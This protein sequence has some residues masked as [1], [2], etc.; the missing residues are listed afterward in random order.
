M[1]KSDGKCFAML[2]FLVFA[3]TGIIHKSKDRG[4]V[5]NFRH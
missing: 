3:D 4:K 1:R 2:R 5:S